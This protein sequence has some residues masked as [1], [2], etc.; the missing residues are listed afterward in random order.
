MERT[1]E[2]V[3]AGN[4][5]CFNALFRVLGNQLSQQ[6]QQIAFQASVFHSSHVST[7]PSNTS[8]L[9]HRATKANL[10]VFFWLFPGL[11]IW[12]SFSW[13]PWLV[14]V[15]LSSA[16]SWWEFQLCPGLGYIIR[17][18]KLLLC[19]SPSSLHL[20][21]QLAGSWAEQFTDLE[22]YVCPPQPVC[23]LRQQHL[24]CTNWKGV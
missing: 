6:I 7:I 15:N 11:Q 18:P 9:A 19:K 14:H 1:G 10:K 17:H 23:S 22:M 21:E 12:L 2:A 5:S 24:R 16:L 20:Q 3:S 13:E 4:K 8:E